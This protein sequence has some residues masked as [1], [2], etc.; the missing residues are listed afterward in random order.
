[1]MVAL[2]TGGGDRPYAFGLTKALAARNVD[3]DVIAGDDLESPELRAFP[4]VHILNLRRNQRSEA[5][6][7][8]KFY[9]LAAY[10][11][12]LFR[13]A[14]T[15]EAH[16][17]H[18][19]WN[20]KVEVFDRTLLMLYYRML[21]KRLVLTVHNVNARLRDGND[22]VLNRFTLRV[23]YRLS[24]HIFVHTPKMQDQLAR[25]F[26]VRAAA[27]TVIPFGI[28]NA[29]PHTSISR[30]EARHRLGIAAGDRT[31]LFFGTI[32][33]YKGVEYLVSAFQELCESD[34]KCR[35]VIAGKPRAGEEQYW[36][37]VQALIQRGPYAERVVQNISFVSDDDTECYFKAADVAVLPYT[38]IFQSGVLFLA[39]SFG[40]PVIAADVG[41][42]KEDILVGETGFVFPAGNA[43]AL[44]GAIRTYF[45]SDLFATLD[46][47]RAAIRLYAD[48]HHSWEI[49]ADRTFEVYRRNI[50]E[51]ALRDR[52]GNFQK[53]ERRP[54]SRNL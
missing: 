21:G 14:A 20:N 8:R 26:N 16:I 54:P 1:M 12:R 28:N 40:L 39:Y 36:S 18:I 32:A 3:L 50:D 38:H 13:Y 17:F 49:V 15:S 53:A 52:A 45:A 42:L 46:K 23:Q 7:A 6:L 37:S 10:Y 29:V 9:R 48:T 35:L 4:N 2:L 25:D 41:D 31:I 19:L 30:A 33:P 34:T 27:V 5:N 44:A 22:S 47:R 51:T 24:D 11:F 43:S